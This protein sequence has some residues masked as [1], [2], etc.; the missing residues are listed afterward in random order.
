MELVQDVVGGKVSEAI[1]VDTH[2]EVNGVDESLKE[3]QGEQ[4]ID[5]VSKGTTEKQMVEPSKEDLGEYQCCSRST[6]SP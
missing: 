2:V 1:K 5:D 3:K 6:R 4:T